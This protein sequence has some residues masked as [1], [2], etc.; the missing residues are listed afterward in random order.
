MPKTRTVNG[1]KQQSAFSKGQ[2][3]TVDDIYTKDVKGTSYIFVENQVIG[4][5]TQEL[6]PAFKG[7]IE[8]ISFPKNMRWAEQ[9]LRYA[10]PVRWIVA[11][12]GDEVIPFEIAGVKTG[13]KTYGHR[14]LGDEVTLTSP[15]NYVRA[16]EEQY[17][18]ADPQRRQQ[19]IADGLA[20]LED[21]HGFQIPE[22]HELLQEVRNLVEYPTV[23]TG[24]FDSAY[25]NL[26]E[27]V[28]TTSMKEH[29]RYFPV[30]D[31][32]DKLLPYFVSVR[33]GDD[34]AIETVKKG[35]EKVLRARLSDAQFFFEEDQKQTIDYYLNKLERIV[36]QEKLGTISDKVKRIRKITEQLSQWLALDGKVQADAARAAEICKFDLPTNMVNEFT[37]LQGIIGET[38][39]LNAGENKEVAH[40]IAEHYLPV[41]ADG[42]TSGDT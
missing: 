8:S 36:F 18:I 23:F 2:G 32:N 3:K 27:D 4:K 24:S 17:V 13:N 41:Q 14:F 10:R 31:T 42:K 28:L 39:A 26:P 11:L 6:L 29:Q 1:R 16:L 30:K 25:L 35:N 40:A 5:D 15:A 34:H 7:I 19:L 22:D 21:E 20:D 33:N 9:S 12:F 37:N 38:Y